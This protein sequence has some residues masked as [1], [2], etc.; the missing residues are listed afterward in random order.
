MQKRRLPSAGLPGDEGEPT[1]PLLLDRPERLGQRG[2]LLGPL[3]QH[4]SSPLSP[5]NR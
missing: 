1:L 2:K 3:E 4:V 5:A